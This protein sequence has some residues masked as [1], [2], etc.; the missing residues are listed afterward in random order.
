MNRIACRVVASYLALSTILCSPSQAQFYQQTNLVSDVPGIA[1]NTDANLKNPWGIAFGATSPFWLANQVSGTS[2]L[3]DGTGTPQA[4]VVTVPGGNPTGA[5]FN[6]T[7][8]FPLS[9]GGQS[10]FMFAT[11]NGSI[12]G[13]NPAL[14][15][16]AEVQVTTTDAVYTGLALGNNGAGNFLYAVNA[17]GGVDIFDGTF[18]P[19]TLAGSFVDPGLPAGFTPYNIANIAGTLYVTYEN[20]TSGGGVIDKF[21]FNGN[22]VGRLTD[23]SDG[24]PLDS[25]W[26]VALAP[27]GFGGTFGGALLVGNEDDGHISA[28]EMS[29]GAF[30]GQ[31]QK[32]DGTPIANTGL[33]GLAFGNGGDGFDPNSL[34]FAA[35]V[36]EQLNGL[37]GRLNPVPEPGTWL[38]V[39]EFLLAAAFLSGASEP[40]VQGTTEARH[41]SHSRAMDDVAPRF[42]NTDFVNLVDRRLGMCHCGLNANAAGARDRGNEK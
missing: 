18:A 35:G 6:S 28:F 27:A 42:G 7:P 34:Y 36:N 5:V 30:I 26:G 37:F 9:V 20:E 15:T 38:F 17:E 4:L 21:D 24:G 40:S 25:P 13:W 39:V 31:L 19:A 22:F 2:T 11:L 8:D 23:N 29:T 32:P 12:A 16:T 33:W 1:A 10:L 14:G 3:Y 41:C